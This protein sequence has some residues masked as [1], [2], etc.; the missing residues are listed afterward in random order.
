MSAGRII[1]QRQSKTYVIARELGRVL[2]SDLS[3]KDVLVTAVLRRIIKTSPKKSQRAASGSRRP[4]PAKR[5]AVAI[6]GSGRMGTALGL[7]LKAIG[8]RIE[9]V[10]TKRPASAKRAARIFGSGTLALSADQFG[11]L[12]NDHVDRLNR[13][14]VV[15]IATPDDLTGSIALQLADILEAPKRQPATPRRR[16]ALHT[17]GALGSEILA[18]MRTVGFAIGSLHPLVSI[19]D[20]RAGAELLPRAFFAVEGD[21]AAIRTAQSLVGEL[22]GQSFQIDPA[23]K[24]LYHAAALTASP[25]MTALFDIAVDMLRVCG[26]KPERARQI[27]LPLVE[28]TLANL[29]R[30][31]PASALT[32]T[33]KRGDQATVEKHLDALKEADLPQALAVYVALGQRSVAMARRVSSNA[34][35]FDEVERILSRERGS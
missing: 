27:L 7:A 1:D 8:Y 17:S 9:I 30:Q 25:Q 4:E 6:I 10:T 23:R 28:S 20:S 26:L 21:A 5:P 14:T 12:H 16:V 35:N 3:K 15:L 31:D 29:A 32:G 13:C 33:F 2:E 18:P 24:A 34:P 11:R 22:G 19:S